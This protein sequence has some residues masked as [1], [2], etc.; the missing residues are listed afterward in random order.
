MELF[1]KYQRNVLAV[2]SDVSMPRHG[3]TDS[4]AGL[5]FV[6]QLR[7]YD[8]E[9]PV[10]MQS[11]DEHNE[12][13]AREL[14]ARFINKSSPSLLSEIRSFLTENLGFGDFIFRMPDGREVARARDVREMREILPTIPAESLVYHGRH[15]HFSIWLMARSEFDLAGRIRPQ[16]V[17]DFDDTEDVREN[18]IDKLR[19]SHSSAHRGMISDFDPHRFS[20]DSFIR[21]G[22]GSLGGKARGIAYLN[23]ALAQNEE[24]DFGGMIVEVPRTIVIAAEEFD[25]FLDAN[26]LREFAVHCTDDLEIAS[27]FIEAILP[28]AL[29]RDLSV[30][31]RS[32]TGPLAVR[33]SSL[34][35]DSLHQPFAG[36]YST[37]MFPNRGDSIEFRMMQL[38]NAIKLVY[39]SAF[40]R[41]AK[42][43]LDN[44]GYRAEE[45]KMAIIIQNVVGAEHGDRFYPSFSGVAQSYNYYPIGPQKA[46]DGVV[47]AAL[48]LGRLVVDGG[49]ALR[50]SPKH[51]EVL[52]QFSSPDAVLDNS[53]KGFYALDLRIECCDA[54]SVLEQY[55]QWYDLRDAEHDQTLQFIGSV[56]H[57]DDERIVED[58][59]L[60]GPRVVTFNN[61]LKHQSIPFAKAISD[62][63]EIAQKGMGGAVEVEFACEMG[64]F[65]RTV[66]RGKKRR[67]PKL[68][69]LQ[70]RPFIM[71]GGN[72]DI[73][74]Y[75]I[76]R[77]QCLCRS[78]QSLGQ[79][80]FDDIEDIVFV[81]QD[82]WESSK[83][84]RI[85]GEVGKL[86]DILN[87]EK[88]PYLLIGPG[89]WGSADEWLGIPVQW[90]QIN[91]AKVIVEASPQGYNV[92]PSQGTHFFQNITSL[93]IGYLTIPP[94]ADI[95]D[96][97]AEAF[98][99]WDWLAQCEIV[100]E[101][102][103]LRH[104]RLPRALTVVLDGQRGQ[105]DVVKPG[106]QI[107]GGNSQ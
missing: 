28:D 58:F 29:R 67:S 36:I 93:R 79:G 35:E 21:I 17:S 40:F 14:S 23:L 100:N 2:I 88:R 60:P 42:S 51:P 45:E 48:G 52:P 102:K 82:R 87:K 77:R 39:A 97:K 64:D 99:D 103:H 18:L 76:P 65:G 3:K 92:D 41:N 26:G 5:D 15:N 57:K 13:K 4:E 63:L 73:V 37:V 71:R 49:Q 34:L 59:N 20:H 44:T 47:H 25:N 27:R 33:S 98:V 106:F 72:V 95:K 90:S 61:I 10:L 91:Y 81:R 53:Q 84:R 38:G 96:E 86:N 19:E 101:T 78:M 12:E 22:M 46:E 62:V 31:L 85:A 7:R 16:K 104:V 70:V 94:G 66:R 68:Y 8:P 30:I 50:F 9:L 107:S 80:I 1:H 89:R 55:E 11:S 43:Y 32:V 69:V 56:Y 83:N 74:K 24:F 54:A 75:D 6:R 105:A